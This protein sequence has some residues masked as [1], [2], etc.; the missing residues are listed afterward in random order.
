MSHKT[1]SK[2]KQVINKEQTDESYRAVVVPI[3]V[4]ED[5]LR[6]NKSLKEQIFVLSGEKKHADDML[7]EY[8][9]TMEE[10][11]KENEELKKYVH[12][13]E[14]RISVIEYE[15]CVLRKD[16]DELKKENIVLVSKVYQLE[17]D[18]VEFTSKIS[19]LE[20]ENAILKNEN[21]IL[22]KD[23]LK[24]TDRVL[25]LENYIHKEHQ[26]KLRNA[27]LIVIQDINDYFRIRD[28]SHEPYKTYLE[29]IRRTRVDKCHY[30]V[31]PLD[32][33]AIC[34]MKCV[35]ALRKLKEHPEIHVILN[36][37]TRC[38]TFVEEFI[39]YLEN[40]EYTPNVSEED[41]EYINEW[42]DSI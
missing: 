18:N 1:K 16:N 20:K 36:N 23:N 9:K 38:K 13:L 40:N 27:F 35:I 32:S 31:K 25:Q 42:W 21:A 24:L 15:N 34:E 33:D 12:S 29:R 8:K 2:D 3:N 37:I 7:K 22:K 39:G 26:N 28:N 4:Y 30:I 5:L 14:E 19:Q 6:E 10:L 41:I 11:Q 17:K